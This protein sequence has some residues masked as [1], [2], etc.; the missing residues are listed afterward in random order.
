MG[1]NVRVEPSGRQFEVAEGETVL[2]AAMR[3]HIGMPYG[4]KDGACASCKCKMT[5]GSVVHKPYQTAALSPEEQ[6]QGMVLPCRAL[7]QEDLVLEAPQVTAADAFP[8]RKMPARVSHLERLCPDVMQVTLQLPPN[9]PLQFHAGQYIDVLLPNGQRRS[10]SMASA[11]HQINPAQPLLDLH[12]RHMPGGTFTDHVFAA[13]KEKEILRV[14]GPLGS[15]YVR[16]KTSAKPLVFLAS[17]TGFAPVKAML[18]DLVHTG[19]TRPATLYWG[20]RRPHDAYMHAWMRDF[21]A[22]HAHV[23]YVPVVSDAL[24][25]DVWEGE[26][27]LA[28][29]VMLREIPDMR[30][31]E[32]YACGTPIMVEVAHARCTTEAGLPETAFYSDA[33]V[34]QKDK[35]AA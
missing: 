26:R 28:V 6:A 16:E 17:G 29:D 13:M 11:P 35:A 15:F 9:A 30:D 8:V 18:E 3:Q 5:S 22:V 20:V 31:C 24:P 21:A 1:F 4:C 33:F 14:E 27:G 23:R 19:S 12:I 10:Y 2:E 34:S 7:P 32:V 25:E